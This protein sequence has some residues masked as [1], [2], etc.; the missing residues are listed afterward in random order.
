MKKLEALRTQLEPAE[1]T[2]F[3][4]SFHGPNCILDTSNE[5]FQLEQYKKKINRDHLPC[6]YHSKKTEGVLSK[7]TKRIA[8]QTMQVCSLQLCKTVSQSQMLLFTWRGL[9]LLDE[10]VIPKSRRWMQSCSW[11][12]DILSC[13]RCQLAWSPAPYEGH[14]SPAK[15]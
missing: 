10:A 11:L 1:N 6:S 7:S 3:P 5:F 8:W 14:P 13:P 4:I 15:T 9:S 12:P 2:T